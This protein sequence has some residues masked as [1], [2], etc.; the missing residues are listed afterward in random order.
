MSA[1]CD[2]RSRAAKP[3]TVPCLLLATLAFAQPALARARPPRQVSLHFTRGAHAASCIDPV[4]LARKV[5]AYTGPV[6][7]AP[8]SAEA[9]VE[10]HVEGLPRGGFR[11]HIQLATPGQGPHGERVLDYAAPDCRSFDDALAF[12]IATTIDPDLVLE[13]VGALFD[14]QATPAKETLLSELDEAPVPRSE[15][16]SPAKPPTTLAVVPPPVM[17]KQ[18]APVRLLAIGLQVSG[19]LP[20]PALGPL[21]GARLHVRRWLALGVSARA[22]IAVREHPVIEQGDMQTQLG[23]A[24]TQLF[25]G[26]LLACPQLPLDARFAT[27][28][29]VGPELALLRAAGHGFDRSTSEV[30]ASV[31]ALVRAELTAELTGP[32]SLSLAAFATFGKRQ[33][34]VYRENAQAEPFFSSSPAAFGGELAVRRAF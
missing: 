15:V 2:V 26:A 18:T 10:A 31:R 27:A 29:C 20:E 28:L 6:L 25:A 4:S 13:K 33:R 12:V 7:V 24:S 34:L 30:R 16:V 21:L 5:E 8:S 19:E 14:P 22:T 32:Y 17:D 3:G 1:N 11:A 23:S 9:A